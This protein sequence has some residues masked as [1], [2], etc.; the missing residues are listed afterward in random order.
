MKESCR[1]FLSK[2]LNNSQR[3]R[4]RTKNKKEEEQEESEEEERT[5]INKNRNV[6]QKERSQT[7]RESWNRVQKDRSEGIREWSI[8]RIER[9]PN[10]GIKSNPV[11]Y[12]GPIQPSKAIQYTNRKISAQ[13]KILSL[14]I[15]RSPTKTDHE[16]NSLP[17]PYIT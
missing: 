10:L 15:E 4:R 3:K 2:R 1:P 7:K 6:V 9:S 5:R 8:E 13:I 14:P 11:D 17:N 16:S 12:Y